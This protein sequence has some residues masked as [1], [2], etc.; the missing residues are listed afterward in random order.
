MSLFPTDG[1]QYRFIGIDPG[2][3]NLGVAVGE[4]DGVSDKLKIVYA[5]TF[6]ISR[7]IKRHE[8]VIE[9][10]GER[11]ARLYTVQ[12]SLAHF[13][14]S[15]KPMLITSE[16]PYLAR[17]AQP[18]A[19]LV[20]CVSAIRRGVIDY[21]HNMPLYVIDPATI[22]THVKVSGKSGDKSLMRKAIQNQTNLDVSAIDIDSLDEHSVDAIA[23]AYA[24][25]LTH[26]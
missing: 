17:H 9:I 13:F 8:N 22:K 4:N 19:A 11:V 6:D 26:R 2:T 18:Y 1:S 24:G 10:H 3:Y 15:W 20:E 25:F 21:K 7:M 14:N 23:I 12:K 5:T 16:G